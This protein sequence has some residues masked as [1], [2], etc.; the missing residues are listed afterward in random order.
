MSTYSEN[1]TCKETQDTASVIWKILME[2]GKSP[3]TYKKYAEKTV[4]EVANEI[5][6]GETYWDVDFDAPLSGTYCH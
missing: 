3:S 1:K 6:K 2:M 5:K 4:E